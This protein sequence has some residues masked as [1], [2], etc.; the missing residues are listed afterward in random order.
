MNYNVSTQTQFLQAVTAEDSSTIIFDKDITL[1]ERAEIAHDM[2]IDLQQHVLSVSTVEG[3]RAVKGKLTILN[4]TIVSSEDDPIT[5]ENSGTCI[6]LGQGLIVNASKCALYVRKRAK[7][8]CAGADIEALGSHAAVFVEGQG[9]AKENTTF[10]LRSG[11]IV[12]QNQ[13]AVSVKS[14][15]VFLMK[16]GHVESRVREENPDKT[17]SVYLYGPRTRMEMSGGEIVSEHTSAISIFEGATCTI[18]KGTV[19][20]H[21]V[22]EPVIHVCGSN[23]CL[24][25]VEGQFTGDSD[26]IIIS[27]LD[28]DQS[29]HVCI[30]GGTF[31]TKLRSWIILCKL[32]DGEPEISIT[33]GRFHGQISA[34]FIAEG[35]AIQTESDG[36][37]SVLPE[38]EISSDPGSR[39]DP[40]PDPQVNFTRCVVLSKPTPVYGSPSR[41]FLIHHVVGC[42][43]ILSVGHVDPVT[44]DQF[45]CVQFV[46]S[47]SGTRS[48]GYISYDMLK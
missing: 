38:D 46:L 17:S 35:Y 7:M 28:A 3:I 4:G 26:I 15:G 44:H 16:G 11:Q 20:S 12:S 24:H 30:S 5:A 42:V 14:C 27:D 23:S 47:G 10:D 48:T 25:I 43:T 32:Q 2:T 41:R 33:R 37:R 40:D 39:P 6:T 13:I 19:A 45:C 36:W 21:A 1:A 8:I 29:T 9:T 34:A 18:T 22:A 31:W